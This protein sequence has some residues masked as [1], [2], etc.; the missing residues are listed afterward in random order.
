[1]SQSETKPAKINPPSLVE[2]PR[3]TSQVSWDEIGDSFETL[4][5]VGLALAIG[6]SAAG[7]FCKLAEQG[8]VRVPSLTS[9]VLGREQAPPKKRNI[10]VEESD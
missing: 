2:Q 3:R 6:M 8:K 1:M 10:K 5:K 7:L 9:L 4:G